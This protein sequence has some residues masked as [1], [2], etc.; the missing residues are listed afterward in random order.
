MLSRRALLAGMSDTSGMADARPARVYLTG[1]RQGAYLVSEE[2][3][4]GSLV[5][6]PDSSHRT[7]A[8]DDFRRPLAQFL[9]SR[10]DSFPTSREALDAWGVALFDDESVAEFAMADVDKQHG[11][12]ALTNQRFIFLVRGRRSL[13]PVQQHS[14]RQL[15]SVERHGR[16]GRAGLVV[17]WKEA[18]PTVIESRDRAQ[19]ERLQTGLLAHK[20]A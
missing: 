9:T 12:V 20:P 7:R 4:D 11:F 19:L 5:L 14:L 10:Q 16:R 3:P 18:A 2:R 13:Q 15:I 6:T 1:H 17:I 8:A